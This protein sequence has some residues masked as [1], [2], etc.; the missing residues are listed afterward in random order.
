LNNQKWTGCAVVH[1]VKAGDDLLCSVAVCKSVLLTIIS[2]SFSLFPPP[3]S[4]VH[5]MISSYVCSVV[6]Y[7]LFF[8]NQ[9]QPLKQTN[10]KDIWF[11][12][13]ELN[14]YSYS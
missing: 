1:I 4:V 5:N 10:K 9:P 12:M 7:Y 6:I 8:S 2:F 13:T 14:F 3:F 11:L